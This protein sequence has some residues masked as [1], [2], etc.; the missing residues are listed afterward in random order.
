MQSL[1]VGDFNSVI[2]Y[3][4]I[5]ICSRPVETHS[6]NNS[7]KWIFQTEALFL[8]YSEKYVIFDLIE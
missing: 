5:E 3:C 7:V 1:L 8:L 4:L 2:D 6:F